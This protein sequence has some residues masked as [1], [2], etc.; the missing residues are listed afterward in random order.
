MYNPA[1]YNRKKRQVRRQRTAIWCMAIAIALITLIYC[2]Q[3][4]ETII[5]DRENWELLD[6]CDQLRNSLG[7]ANY[8]IGLLE[9]EAGK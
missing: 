1:D 4:R 6:K 3:L 5:L 2:F 7:M 9:E 8:E